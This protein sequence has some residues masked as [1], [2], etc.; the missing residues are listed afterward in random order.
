MMQFHGIFIATSFLLSF[1]IQATVRAADTPVEKKADREKRL[2][3]MKQHAGEFAL[4]LESNSETSLQRTAEPV[5]RYSNPVRNFFSDGTLYFWLDGKRPVAALSVSIRGNKNIGRE[6]TSLTNQSL[7]CIWQQQPIWSPNAG[8]LFQQKLPNAPDSVSN[9]KLR[10]SQM[11]RLARRFNG[12]FKNP[13]QNEYSE[14]RLLTQPVYRYYDEK[15]GIVDGAIFAFSQSNDPE[16]LLILEAYRA[17]PERKPHWR[18]SV[19]RMS[20]MPLQ[21][22]LD[23]K[24]I[25]TA[26]GYWRNSRT[27]QDPYLES[28]LKKKR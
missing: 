26:R 19:V 7:R 9:G 17:A 16:M 5:L 6:L 15:Q 24:E 1:P 3:F 20:S 11:R 13:N 10:L 22:R 27:P 21:V 18:Y 8:K 14:S 28:I 25:W 12:A 23:G 2:E 4:Y